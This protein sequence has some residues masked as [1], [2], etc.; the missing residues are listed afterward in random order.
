MLAKVPD[1]WGKEPYEVT[2]HAEEF[3]M[4]ILVCQGKHF[5]THFRFEE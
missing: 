5:M 1:I 3:R 2:F 4:Y